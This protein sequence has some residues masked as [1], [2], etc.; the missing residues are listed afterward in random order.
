MKKL[1]KI[2]ERERYKRRRENVTK[3]KRGKR[4]RGERGIYIP[5]SGNLIPHLAIRASV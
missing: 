4:E 3:R 1:D 5:L 2:K